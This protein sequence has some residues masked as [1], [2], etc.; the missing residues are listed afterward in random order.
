MSRKRIRLLPVCVLVAGILTA[1]AMQ[2]AITGVGGPAASN[3]GLAE[4]I[5]TPT[6]MLDDCVNSRNGIG[7]VV[8]QGFD[9]AQDVTLA[10]DITVD[11]GV[12]ISAGTKVSS[13]MI[14]F[15][16]GF[17]LSFTSHDGVAWTFGQN[18][19]GV[20]TLPDGVREA[21]SSAQLGAAGTNYSVVPMSPATSVRLS[22]AWV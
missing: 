1:S 22:S 13:H 4:K 12:V 9:E 7:Q 2:A 17:P 21:N 3:G 8:M 18:I 10:S 20:I 15:N 6:D 14:F 19:I 5:A 11:G 16:S